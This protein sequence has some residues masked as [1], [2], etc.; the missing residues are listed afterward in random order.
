MSSLDI[1]STPLPLSTVPF[2]RDPDFVDIGGL[3][4][5][6]HFRCSSQTER[7]VIFVGAGGTG[8][9]H[10]AIEYSYRVREKSPDTWVLWINSRTPAR[11]QQSCADLAKRVKAPGYKNPDANKFGIL[12]DWLQNEQPGRWM[13]VLDHVDNADFFHEVGLR[14]PGSLFDLLRRCPNGA[15]ILTTRSFEIVEQFDRR[16]DLVLIHPMRSIYAETLLETKLKHRATNT[17]TVGMA[18]E[19]LMFLQLG[20]VI[21]AAYI[22]YRGATYSVGRYV[23]DLC[24]SEFSALSLT[25]ADQH[26]VNM[27]ECLVIPCQL[28]I[29]YILEIR[30]S[31]AALLFLASF[32]DEQGIPEYILRNQPENEEFDRDDTE[33]TSD[34]SSFTI[35]DGFE[36]DVEVLKDFCLIAPDTTGRTFKMHNL[37]QW[38]TKKWLKA[39]G[40]FDQWQ[41]TFLTRISKEFPTPTT[42]TWETCQ[43]LFPHVQTTITDHPKGWPN[44]SF[45]EWIT[46]IHNAASFAFRQGDIP[47]AQEM[48]QLALE[49]QNRQVSANDPSILATKDF[50]SQIY[51]SSGHW[52]SAEA[53][54]T[55][56]LAESRGILGHEHPDTLRRQAKLLMLYMKQG[57]Y[58][59]A[60]AGYTELSASSKRVLG[61]QNPDTLECLSNLATALA[62]Q[63]KWIAAEIALREAINGS[64]NILGEGNP[65]TLERMKSLVK[66]FLA[67]GRARAREAEA[68][69]IRVVDISRAVF[70][71]E[72][73][74]TVDSMNDLIDMH[75][76]SNKW[77]AAEALQLHVLEVQRKLLGED[78]PTILASMDN[79]VFLC[80]KQERLHD[81]QFVQQSIIEISMSKLGAEH[82]LTLRAMSKL[83]EIRKD[84]IELEE[85]DAP[86]ELE[87]WL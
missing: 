29:E 67:F 38:S 10:L 46:L 37:V 17:E 62:M 25:D 11:F 5:Q 18:L 78:H 44:E 47:V 58:E 53:L 71:P 66:V 28:A 23:D 36:D 40:E 24:N 48:M 63:E 80:L 75:L 14:G 21:A 15:I 84:I 8:K 4:G 1:E 72:H 32:F 6:V 59:D 34:A 12:C 9:S 56:I 85:R 2:P 86:E 69:Q 61:S 55:E 30:P 20:I 64:I 74:N 22:N 3:V 57:R 31:A 42:E 81:A 52:Q 41:Q 16:G 43:L 82:Y 39:H 35:V 13:L 68:L 79:L 27:R 70:G 65:T 83:D 7:P 51:Y 76:R 33:D 77:E 19:E 60:E 45:T 49:E 87:R 50:M 26:H 54:S 73:V